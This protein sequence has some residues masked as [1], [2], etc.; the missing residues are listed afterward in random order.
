MVKQETLDG[1]EGKA[2]GLGLTSRERLRLYATRSHFPHGSIEEMSVTDE[3]ILRF[4][5]KGGA[6]AETALKTLYGRYAQHMLKFFVYQ[7][8]NGEEARDVFQE[9]V[10]KIVRG[11]NSYGGTG[12]ARAWIWQIARNCMMDALRRRQGQEVAANEDEWQKISETAAEPC[13]R[14][15][16]EVQDCVNRGLGVFAD[17]APE[18]ALVLTLFMEG[19]SIE[20][21]GLRIGR[22]TSAT[23]EFLSQCRKKIRDYVSHCTELL[24][25]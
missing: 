14:S 9:T 15:D 24:E 5:P 21:I 4:I 11:A 20:E 12:T 23:K 3:E 2:L 22:T 6:V 19:L 7:G 1:R 17:H 18:R 10:I 16:L 25:A 13:G 8:I